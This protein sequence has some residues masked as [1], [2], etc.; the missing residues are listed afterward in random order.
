VTRGDVY[1][2]SLHRGRGREQR[3]SRYGVI[4]QAAALLDLSTVIVAPTSTGAIPLTF[5]PQIEIEGARTRVMVEQLRAVDPQRLG[6]RV[7]H[8]TLDEQHAVD[9][10]L[11]SVLNL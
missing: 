8:L 4:V 10:A 3:R 2:L 6:K 1:E 9:Q 11:R 7:H 5:R